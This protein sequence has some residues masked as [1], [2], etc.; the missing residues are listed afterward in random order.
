[1]TVIKRHAVENITISRYML[2]AYNA[3]LFLK[4]QGPSLDNLDFG[5]YL[6]V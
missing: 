5:L 4:D 2:L 6:Y 1:M 3:V